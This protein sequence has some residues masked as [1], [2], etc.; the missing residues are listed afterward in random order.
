[1][2]KHSCSSFLFLLSCFSFHSLV[3]SYGIG[4]GAFGSSLSQIFLAGTSSNVF[5]VGIGVLS[6]FIDFGIIFSNF[7][8]YKKHF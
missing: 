3:A 7:R 8:K 2:I 4:F 1:M 5:L 6:V